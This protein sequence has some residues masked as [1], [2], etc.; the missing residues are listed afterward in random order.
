MLERRRDSCSVRLQAD[1]PEVRLKPDITAKVRLK[2]DTTAERESTTSPSGP[3]HSRVLGLC[4]LSTVAVAGAGVLGNDQ[5]PGFTFRALT[6]D[7][8]VRG[9]TIFG[10]R[11]ANRYLLETTGAGV[12]LIDYD[13]D[14]RLDI[15]QVNGTTIEGAPKGAEPR[16]YLY[17]NHGGGR[18][19]DVTAASGLREQW[20][21]GQGACVGDYDNDGHDDLL[22]TYYGQNRLFRNT[23]RAGFAEVTRSA[24]LVTDARW[25]TGCAFLDVDR[26]GHLDLFVAN[27]IDL[28]LRTA[29]TPESG[30][31]RYKGVAVACGPPGLKG[32]TNAL[33][34]NRGDGTFVDVSASSGITAAN[35]TYALGVST[36]DFDNDGWTD[37]Y[38]ANDSNPS[39]LYRNRGD[40]TFEDIGVRAGC[41]Y[42]QDGKPQAGMGVGIG[43]YDRNGWMDIVKTN[44]AGDTSSLYANTG[45]GRCQD[46][47]FE[48]G[49]G[50]NTRWLGWG[51]GFADFDNDGWLDIFLTNGHVYPEVRQ[52]K[53]EAGY[54]QRKV[55][56]RNIGGRFEDVTLRLGAPATTPKAGRGTAFGDLDGNGTMDVV[57]NNVHDTPDVWLTSATAGHHW[58][59]LRLVGTHSNRSAIGARVRVVSDGVAQIREVHGGGSYL[60][61]NDLRVHVGLGGVRVAARVEVRWPNGREEAWTDVAADQLLTLT[62]GQGTARR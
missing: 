60:S 54:E 62:E 21:W 42:S 56:Y 40:G 1:S 9:V 32:G 5:E 6:A 14:G 11:T 46:R 8:G 50:T 41:A 25:G 51:A 33:Y 13:D 35:G 19:E 39:A 44:F 12:A 31:C 61:Q 7:A 28:D 38:V 36:L 24:G 49:L 3:R 37:L 45:T 55:V 23:G 18:F 10:G 43:D 2:P 59:M 29:P 53:G 15:F 57:V 48:A 4:L 22:V 47:T 27:Y 26:D 30:V 17:R 34:R 16:P 58:L 20:G 52:I